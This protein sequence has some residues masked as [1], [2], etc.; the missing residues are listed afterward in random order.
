M[1]GDFLGVVQSRISFDFLQL[2][3]QQCWEQITNKLFRQ[4]SDNQVK[5]NL[6]KN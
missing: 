4:D 3:Y 1:H 5:N 6:A 2:Y